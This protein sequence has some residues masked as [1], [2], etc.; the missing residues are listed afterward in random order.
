MS[1]DVGDVPQFTANPTLALPRL[2]REQCLE[3]QSVIALPSR[4]LPQSGEGW[5]GVHR[6]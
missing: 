1:N 4:P 6:A 2:G 5:D 3:G